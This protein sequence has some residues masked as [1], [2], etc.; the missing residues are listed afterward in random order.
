MLNTEDVYM[1]EFNYH[2]DQSLVR[3]AHSLNASSDFRVL[4]RLPAIGEIWCQSGP[5][6]HR[7]GVLRVAVLD[8]ETTG[9]YP[10]KNKLVEL[11]VCIIEICAATGKLLHIEPPISWLEDPEMPLTDDVMGLTHLTDADL[12]GQRFDEEKIYAALDGV[13]VL[14]AHHA[15]FDNAFIKQRFPA[16]DLPWACS[17]NDIQWTAFGLGMAGKSISALLTESGY[18]MRDAHRAAADCWALAVLLV[19]LASD[20]RTRLAHLL[21][22]ARRPTYRLFAMGAPF[23]LKDVLKA[24]EYRWCPARRAWWIENE[25]ERLGNDGAWLKSLCP[26]IRPEMV[27]ITWFD[28]HSS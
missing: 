13:Q 9:L 1:S 24:A 18:F 27:K 15:V 17:L 16:L 6:V 21:E 11:A 5:V 14:V 26:L 7:D 10:V 19:M 8:T 25:P 12:A 4:R 28:R 2:L 23:S 22:A 20:G 3:Q